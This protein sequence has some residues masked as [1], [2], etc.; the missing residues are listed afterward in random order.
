[1]LIELAWCWLKYQPQSE[2]TRRYR[3]RFSGRGSRTGEVGIVALA[4]KLAMAFWRFIE[5]GV[6]PEGAT[7][8][9]A[10]RFIER[11]PPVAEPLR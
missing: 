5:D 3:Y 2:L 9:I 4:R 1:M 11:P 6:V 10:P 7:L 8:S